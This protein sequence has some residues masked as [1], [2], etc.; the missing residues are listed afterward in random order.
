MHHRTLILASLLV[1]ASVAA[2]NV[3]APPLVQES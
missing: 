2:Q 3:P 1:C